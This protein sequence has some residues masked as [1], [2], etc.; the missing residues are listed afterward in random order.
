MQASH[1]QT[2]VGHCGGSTNTGQHGKDCQFVNTQSVLP[3]PF[4][5]GGQ[6]TTGKGIGNA[7]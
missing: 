7:A 1:A 4:W 3:E 6:I 5:L 2:A